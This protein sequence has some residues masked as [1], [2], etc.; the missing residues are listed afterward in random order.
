ME[1]T[2][3]TGDNMLRLTL[4]SADSPVVSTIELPGTI[5][6]AE[7]GR[8]LGIEFPADAAL[9]A[10]WL[11]DPVA[12]PLTS[13]A[14]DGSAYIQ[15]TPPSIVQARSASIIARGDVDAD[16]RMLAVAIPRRGAGYEI[17]YPSGNQ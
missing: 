8:L 6:V 16:G 2:V 4:T 11:A 13:L 12:G 1:L 5:D 15:I 9:L 10:A 17:S 14:A 3:D 7:Q